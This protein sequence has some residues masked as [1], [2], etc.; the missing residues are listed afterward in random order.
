MPARLPRHEMRR[1]S[2]RVVALPGFFFSAPDVATLDL[3]SIRPFSRRRSSPDWYALHL[4]SML[5]SSLNLTRPSTTAGDTGSTRSLSG[6]PAPSCALRRYIS[7]SEI[8]QLLPG[9]SLTWIA[10]Y[11]TSSQRR[12]SS[13]RCVPHWLLAKCPNGHAISL[14]VAWAQ[15]HGHLVA[16]ASGLLYRRHLHA[17]YRIGWWKWGRVVGNE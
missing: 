8:Y 1:K 13:A 7:G 16:V 2:T 15:A 5:P 14:G 17:S 4:L 9:R 10:S 12:W 6:I 3:Q 11:C